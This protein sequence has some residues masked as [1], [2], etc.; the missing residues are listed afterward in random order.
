[1]N[2]PE[3]IKIDLHNPAYFS[4]GVDNEYIAS[5]ISPAYCARDPR[6]GKTGLTNL[7]S[8]I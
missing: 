4:D 1:M 7:V 8:T 5:L 2:I 6:S 3:E